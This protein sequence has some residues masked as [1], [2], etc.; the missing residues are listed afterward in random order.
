[1]IKNNKADWL[2]FIS[3]SHL[4]KKWAKWLQNKLEYYKLPSYIKKEN[5]N[6]PSSL[7]PIFRDE[8]DLPLG[9]LTENIKKA[10]DS[11]LFLIVICSRNAVLSEYV[12][13]EINYFLQRH[14]FCGVFS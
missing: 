14:K 9:L 10:L 8:T 11:S 12:D 7:R 13:D 1:M 5:P 4:D 3:Y 6:L 2:A